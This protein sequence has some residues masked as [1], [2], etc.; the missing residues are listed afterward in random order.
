LKGFKLA[1]PTQLPYTNAQVAQ[2]PKILVQEGMC[3]D[4]KDPDIFFSE[5]IAEQEIAISLCAICPVLEPCLEYAIRNEMY[6]IWAGTTPAERQTLNSVSVITPEFRR[7][8][9]EIRYD[10]ESEILTVTQ[11]AAKYRVDERSI[12][13]YKARLRKEAS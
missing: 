6:G 9:A 2:L 4:A 12:Y 8:A 10:I 3:N 7:E 13:R 5:E 11:I 1:A